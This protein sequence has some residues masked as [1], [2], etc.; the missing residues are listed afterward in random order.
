MHNCTLPVGPEHPF[1]KEPINL[2]LKIEGEKVI[3]ADINLGYIHRGIEKLFE[4]K[5]VDSALFLASRICGI[6]PI[7]H[8]GALVTALEKMQKI[9]PT[10]KVNNIRVIIH[11]LERLQS[12]LLWIGYFG[13]EIGYETLFMFS[14]REREKIMDILEKITGGRIH[15][16]LMRLGTVRWDIKNEDYQFINKRLNELKKKVSDYYKEVETSRVIKSRAIGVGT[17]ENYLAKKYSL[18]GPVARG[19]GIQIDTRKQDPYYSYKDFDFKIPVKDEGDAYARLFVRFEEIIQAIS[20]IEQALDDMPSE[21]LPEAVPQN[22]KKGL[23]YG[24]T[25]APRGEDIHIVE[26]DNNKIVRVRVRPPTLA[27]LWIL[28]EI[29][30]GT[31]IGDIPVI[32]SSLDPCLS[33]CERMLVVDKNRGRIV[34]EKEVKNWKG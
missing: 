29:V 7:S 5:D 23:N 28:R 32:V 24:R 26:V 17:I 18:V 1:S 10:K 15:H 6:C 14:W 20:I 9:T 30:P 8:T 13:H 25:E 22:I 12:H 34:G 4:K 21:S 11:E 3:D 2:A 31:N 27:Y 19:S 16:S 33:C